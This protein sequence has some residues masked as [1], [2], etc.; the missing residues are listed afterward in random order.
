MANIP[1]HLVNI[2]STTISSCQYSLRPQPGTKKPVLSNL[3]CGPVTSIHGVLTPQPGVCW[4]NGTLYGI[5]DAKSDSQFTYVRRFPTECLLSCSLHT[6]SWVVVLWLVLFLSRTTPGPQ[7]QRVQCSLQH[8]L[9][10]L[11]DV[12]FNTTLE[13]GLHQTL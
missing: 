7:L 5:L 8:L 6:C 4:E 10:T 12:T 11:H 9:A 13:G 1:S 3:F 2:T